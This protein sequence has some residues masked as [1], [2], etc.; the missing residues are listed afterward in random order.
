MVQPLMP[1]ATAVW[2]VDNTA[3]TFKQI[4]EFCGMHE[5]EVEGIANGEVAGS[6]IGKD[7]VAAHQTTKE[8]IE[9]CE[10]DPRASLQL[11]AATETF[12]RTEKKRKK[13]SYTPVARRKDKPD[14]IAWIVKHCPEATDAQIAK[15]IGTTKKTIESV[16]N[17]THWNRANITPRDPVLLGLC[18]Q[19]DL[20]KMIFKAKNSGEGI[21]LAPKAEAPTA[22][23][24]EEQAS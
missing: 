21:A 15:L 3:L 14:A 13:S 22:V 17:K 1:K 6:I 5:I 7:P 16:R 12:I 18:K 23:S 11:I 10:K 20:D 2:L 9:R 8:E 19:S 24:P 4:A